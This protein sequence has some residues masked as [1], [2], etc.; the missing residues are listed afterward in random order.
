VVSRLPPAGRT[1]KVCAW[2]ERG[3][4]IPRLGDDNIVDWLVALAE[5]READ[6]DDHVLLRLGH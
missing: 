2:I 4:H 5:A 1:R 3:R 6:F